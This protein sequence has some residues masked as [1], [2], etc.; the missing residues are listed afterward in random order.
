MPKQKYLLLLPFVL[1]LHGC[2][3]PAISNVTTEIV[4][5]NPASYRTVSKTKVEIETKDKLNDDLLNQNF[6]EVEITYFD[7]SDAIITTE[8]TQT[9]QQAIEQNKR[10]STLVIGGGRG[11]N[12]T[13]D[14]EI[15]EETEKRTYN[16]PFVVDLEGLIFQSEHDLYQAVRE[17]EPELSY[18]W[19]GE[20]DSIVDEIV[21]KLKK[22]EY[23]YMPIYN[24]ATEIW[25]SQ[26]IPYYQVTEYSYK[27][28]KSL[29]FISKKEYRED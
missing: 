26:Y 28:D 6:G 13:Y 22:Q 18:S 8:T 14:A 17:L 29:Q 16:V 3:S 11:T 7:S 1:L 24:A 10:G 19:E 25:D 5:N 9:L 12:I 21:V 27:F 2:I 4:D 23:D 15:G 20:R